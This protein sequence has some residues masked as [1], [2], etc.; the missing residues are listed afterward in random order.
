MYV[1]MYVCMYVYTYIDISDQIS[2]IQ[3]KTLHLHRYTP[4]VHPWIL[5]QENQLLEMIYVVDKP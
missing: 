4:Y 1:C 2:L 3:N 5:S